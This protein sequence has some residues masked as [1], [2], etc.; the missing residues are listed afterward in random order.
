MKRTLPPQQQQPLRLQYRLPGLP[1]SRKLRPYCVGHFGFQVR[2]IPRL[3][4]SV[5]AEMQSDVERR[6]HLAY[7]PARQ[8]IFIG[9]FGGYLNVVSTYSN[10]VRAGGNRPGDAQGA[11]PIKC[12]NRIKVRRAGGGEILAACK[13]GNG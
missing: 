2:A 4:W 6:F 11:I 12:L 10:E 1:Y 9:T 5:E 7:Q 13:P 8:S 3:G